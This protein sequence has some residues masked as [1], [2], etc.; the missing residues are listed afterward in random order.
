MK[1]SEPQ[2]VTKLSVNSGKPKVNK[3]YRKNLRAEIHNYKI[4]KEKNHTNVDYKK[5][6]QSILGKI[7]YVRDFDKTQGNKFKRQLELAESR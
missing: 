6:R 5:R 2:L 7:N 1:N 3:K 4:Q